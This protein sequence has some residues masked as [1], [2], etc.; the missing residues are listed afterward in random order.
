[1]AESYTVVTFF[2]GIVAQHTNVKL[3]GTVVDCR[4]IHGNG[5]IVIYHAF[6]GGSQG[7]ACKETEESACCNALF[8]LL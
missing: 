2:A 7:I 8:S 4:V 6:Y 1:M 5:M 3:N